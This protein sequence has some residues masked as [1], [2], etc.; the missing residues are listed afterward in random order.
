MLV[1]EE[2][3]SASLSASFS[4]PLLYVYTEASRNCQ[5]EVAAEGMIQ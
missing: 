3:L 4:F 2:K 1:V 5:D